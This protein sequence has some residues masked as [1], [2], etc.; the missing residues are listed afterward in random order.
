MP[1]SDLVLS[2]GMD[3]SVGLLALSASWPGSPFV[4][5]C[6]ASLAFVRS[7]G[8][9]GRP[10]GPSSSVL[11][12][13]VVQRLFCNLR[14][15]WSSRVFSHLRRRGPPRIQRGR[16]DDG[17]RP[18]SCSSGPTSFSSFCACVCFGVLGGASV[19][20]LPAGSAVARPDAV[21]RGVRVCC[22]LLVLS[23]PR[24]RGVERRSAAA[25]RRSPQ[26]QGS[27]WLRRPIVFKQL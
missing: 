26:Q 18:W 22:A 21:P 19:D 20:V 11:L 10:V 9:G 5:M 12:L 6:L 2:V 8:S 4:W 13:F 17:T 16:P 25:Q 3:T 7:V 23:L 24:A 27:S 14:V 1:A 15:S